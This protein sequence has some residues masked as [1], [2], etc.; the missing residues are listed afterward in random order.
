MQKCK[1]RN[2]FLF[3]I[4]QTGNLLH[5]GRF[6]IL[7]SQVIKPNTTHIFPIGIHH[8][9]VRLLLRLMAQSITT[10]SIQTG[11]KGS[12]LNLN[13]M[14]TQIIAPVMIQTENNQSRIS[15]G[16]SNLLI[17]QAVTL[18]RTKKI[19]SHLNL[20]PSSLMIVHMIETPLFLNKKKIYH[21][22]SDLINHLAAQ[23]A[24]TITIRT[25]QK[26]IRPPINLL[27]RPRF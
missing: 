8:H 10:I 1:H 24:T 18:I 16:H 6:L 19:G 14:K 12:L 21:L 20:I 17:I 5:S 11:K 27:I 25:E 9:L 15:L 22:N 26:G 4:I 3:K 7:V 23:I 13:L 2:I